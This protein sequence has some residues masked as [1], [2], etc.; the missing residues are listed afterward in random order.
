LKEGISNPQ[1]QPIPPNEVYRIGK[2]QIFIPC[3]PA[4]VVKTL[5][6]INVKDGKITVLCTMVLRFPT[7]DVP[8]EVLTHMMETGV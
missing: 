4:L 2:D 3:Y 1:Y 6:D 7:K 8:E 5:R